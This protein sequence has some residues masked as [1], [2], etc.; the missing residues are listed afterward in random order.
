MLP[1]AQMWSPFR[2]VLL[3]RRK[4]LRIIGSA[5]S[6]FAI[7]FCSLVTL[8]SL[9]SCSQGLVRRTLCA[10]EAPT[11]SRASQKM[12]ATSSL[13]AELLLCNFLSCF[14][15]KSQLLQG[16]QK[17]IASAGHLLSPKS[18]SFCDGRCCHVL[19]CGHR[20]ERFYCFGESSCAL[21]AVLRTRLQSVFVAW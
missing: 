13:S 14:A 18:P 20:F 3:L 11:R 5:S 17:R 6:T 4:Q 8:R 1:C 9:L 7:R 19:S 2:E 12:K 15:L 16:F 21:L 10:R